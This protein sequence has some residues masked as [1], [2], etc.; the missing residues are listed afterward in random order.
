MKTSMNHCTRKSISGPADGY[1]HLPVSLQ[2]ISLANCCKEK[3]LLSCNKLIIS[4]L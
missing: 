4:K 3:K 2:T 1:P